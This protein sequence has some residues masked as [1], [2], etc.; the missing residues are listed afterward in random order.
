MPQAMH[1]T[2]ELN[3]MPTNKDSTAATI[4]QEGDRRTPRLSS[5]GSPLTILVPGKVFESHF[6]LPL[7]PSADDDANNWCL[8]SASTLQKHSRH[9]LTKPPLLP[10]KV[11]L[12]F[13]LVGGE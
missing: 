3:G 11:V 12:T 1:R 10:W 5:P 8:L 9:C 6:T 7:F 4:P 13:A 2:E